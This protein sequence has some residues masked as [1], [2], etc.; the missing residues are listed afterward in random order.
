[1]HESVNAGRPDPR[2]A[3][4]KAAIPAFPVID[5]RLYRIAFL[6]A[7]LA[8]IVVMFSL[9][10]AP[11][12]LEPVTP[13][14]TFEGDRAAAVAR[15]IA[16]TAPDRTAGSAGDEQVADLVAERFDEIPAGAVSEQ[17]F[18]VEVDGESRSLRNVLLTLPGDS[19]STIVVA[20]A[21]DADPGPGAASSAAA[22]GI[23]VELA[24]AFR[25]S[26]EKTFV[27]ASVSGSTAGGAGV[28]ELVGGL[29]ERDTIEA[30]V[31]ISQPGSADRRRPFVITSS[32]GSGSA[33]A[34]LERTAERAVEVQAEGLSREDDAFTQFARIAIPSG[35]GDQ[36]VLIGEGNDA[37]AIS[38]AGER[39]LASDDDQP[40]DVAPETIDEFGR[41]ALSTVAALDVSIADPVHGPDTYVE[42]GNNLLPGWA[43]AVLA[44]ALLAPALVAA[45]DG[46]ARAHR[47]RLE[48][49]AAFAWAGARSLPFVGALAV[50]YLLAAVGAVPRPPFPFDP[51][52]FELGGRAAIAFGAMAVVAVASAWLLR[53]RR[54]T[55]ARAPDPA[56]CGLGAIAV[57]AC[58]LLWLA[59]PY[60]AL[61]VVPIAHLWLLLPGARTV[62]RR[63]AVVTA[64]ALACLPLI[65]ALLAVS[66]ALDLGADAPWTFTLM[67]ADGQVGFATALALCFLGGALAGGIALALHRFAEEG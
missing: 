62:S 10:G 4:C 26:H 33:S 29:P 65:A 2:S 35:L 23:L 54:I 56:A 47:E 60:L 43:L 31:V 36:A 45:V 66:R 58:A 13:P 11:E 50:L 44:L 39:P 61:L 24:N 41:A 27:L 18:E 9:E 28:R 64:G 16:T 53:S 55:A 25:V 15:Q 1:M 22:T 30:V 48:I 21:R 46:L 51:A 40:D 42:L 63:V 32:T 57:A 37:V 17:G 49:G 52:H 34:Q 38:S 12:A 5:F 20:A 6:P 59:N 7:L 8:V 14:T 67:I 19:T 3:R